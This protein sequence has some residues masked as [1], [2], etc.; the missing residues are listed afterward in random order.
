MIL[1]ITINAILAAVA[2]AAVIGVILPAIRSSQRTRFAART[3]VVQLR[4][5]PV[6]DARGARR[7]A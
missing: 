6:A 5:E 3:Q 1:A 7:A 2:F 4:H